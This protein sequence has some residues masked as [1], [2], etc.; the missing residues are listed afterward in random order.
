VTSPSRPEGVDLEVVTPL[1]RLLKRVGADRKS[2]APVLQ[3]TPSKPG[4]SGRL[5]IA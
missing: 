4:T 1:R 2:S 3:E 5:V